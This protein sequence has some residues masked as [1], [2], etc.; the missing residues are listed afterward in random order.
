MVDQLRT[1]GVNVVIFDDGPDPVK[2]DAVFPNNWISTHADGTVYLYPMQAENRRLERRHDIVE[3]LSTE[4]HFRISNITDL[5][6]LELR[7]HF[8]EGTGSLVLDRVNRVA[9]AGLSDRTHPEALAEFAQ[10]ANY[11]I[12]TFPTAGRDGRPIY[13]TNVMMTIGTRFAV[14]CA[15]AICD[16]AKR[17]AV[18]QKISETGRQVVEISLAQTENFAGNM[19]ELSTQSGDTLIVGSRAAWG[20]LSDGQRA[21][22]GSYGQTLQ[23]PLETIELV[24]GGGV[25]CMI[26]EIFLPGVKED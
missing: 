16:E 6:P 23:V 22:I 24:G 14:V 21:A 18:L 25:R 13:H 5:S 17:R 15:E 10:I 2:P 26:A 19:I 7:G 3:R 9:Y 8:L 11:E 20:S 12:A 1:A 4:H